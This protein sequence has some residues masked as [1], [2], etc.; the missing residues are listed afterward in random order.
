MY[1]ERLHEVL[2]S[3]LVAFT[4][5]GLQPLSLQRGERR[6]RVRRVN[7]RWVDRSL[8]PPRHGFS[9]TV[10]TGDVF[11]IQYTEGEPFWRL[12]GIFSAG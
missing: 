7:A 4:P 11:Q 9:V 5:Q 1:E 3:M 12:E 2:R 6:Y 10:H 8:A